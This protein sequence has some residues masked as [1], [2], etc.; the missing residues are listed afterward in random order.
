M[1]INK[2]RSPGK[3]R[4]IAISLAEIFK[5]SKVIDFQNTKLRRYT[6][7]IGELNKNSGA[8]NYELVE[9]YSTKRARDRK[10]KNLDEPST[11]QF[12]TGNT[13][14]PGEIV[15]FGGG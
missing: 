4:L 14:E 13:Y 5:R 6:L 2:T 11:N 15:D 9:T 12:L 7:E 10:L 1:K 8:I 3:L